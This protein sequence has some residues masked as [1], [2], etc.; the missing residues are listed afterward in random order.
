MCRINFKIV[1]LFVCLIFITIFVFLLFSLKSIKTDNCVSCDVKKSENNSNEKTKLDTLNKFNQKEQE[2]VDAI[3]N[4][5]K[6]WDKLDEG[7]LNSFEILSIKSAGY[8]KSKP[9]IR[10]IIVEYLSSCKDGTYNCDNLDKNKTLLDDDGCLLF[11]ISI[12]MNDY[13]INDVMSGISI[14]INSD[15]VSTKP[16]I[17]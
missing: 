6:V 3:Y 2:I 14:S 7:N 17:E 15:W 4:E 11:W 13:S 10:Y 9:D 8:F 1:I 12:N 5:T 16:Y